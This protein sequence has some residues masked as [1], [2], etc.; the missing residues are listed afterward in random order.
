VNKFFWGVDLWEKWVRDAWC[1]LMS[2][3][4]NIQIYLVAFKV[5]RI[6]KFGR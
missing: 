1:G 3:G 6:L 2:R 4:L 5:I